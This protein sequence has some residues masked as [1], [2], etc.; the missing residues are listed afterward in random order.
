MGW[1]ADLWRYGVTPAQRA[2]SRDAERY[3]AGISA[4]ERELDT[5]SAA[6]ARQRAELVLTASP[7][8]RG[9]AWR[10]GPVP[11]VGDLAS[12]QQ[13]FFRRLRRVEAAR[14]G[15]P[16]VDAEELAPYAGH[17][18]Y[19]RLGQDDEHAYLA[20]RPGD[21]ALYVIADDEPLERAPSHRFPTLHHW[22]LWLH[23]S[24]ELLAEPGAPAA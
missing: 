15:E 16:Y 7:F 9:V 18:G 17:P 11:L 23:R 22:V 4:Y 3:A 6:A 12:G 2:A 5:L 8:V 10:D 13:E 21:E 19:L 20:V 24:E 14:H 1:L